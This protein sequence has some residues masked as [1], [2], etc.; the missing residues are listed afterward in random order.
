MANLPIN[1]AIRAVRNSAYNIDASDNYT[2]QSEEQVN[3]NKRSSESNAKCT[4]VEGGGR[5]EKQKGR[6]Q[7]DSIM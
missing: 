1:V 7:I 5:G 3:W 4:H 6:D 2:S